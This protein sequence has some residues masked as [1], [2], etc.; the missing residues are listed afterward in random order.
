MRHAPTVAA[1]FALSSLLTAAR[2]E[3]DPPVPVRMI[4][5]V[6]PSAMRRA[7]TGGLVTVSC[8]IDEKGDVQ[9]LKV[10]KS[11]NDA[12]TEPALDALR[13]WKF[14]PA[15]RDGAI[16]PTRVTIPITFKFED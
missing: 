10:A 13:R 5:P 16:V 4:Q 8:L 12:F 3:F 2:A 11:T 14:K 9:D 7:Q 6:F 1:L 15:Q